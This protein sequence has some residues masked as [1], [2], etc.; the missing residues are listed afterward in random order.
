MTTECYFNKCGHH[1]NNHGEPR[2]GPFCDE[3]TCLANPVQLAE[4]SLQRRIDL[5][6]T[7][8]GQTRSKA[9]EMC[10]DEGCDHHGKPHVCFDTARTCDDYS[11][12][13]D[14]FAARMKD[15]LTLAQQRGKR[16]WRDPSWTDE[17][18]SKDLREHCD[19]GDPVDVANYCMF[20]SDRG[21]SITTTNKEPVK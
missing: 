20:L 18:I 1:S 5:E 12:A 4:W 14:R 16:G 17:Q 7:T 9:P 10:Q 11:D 6:H 13:V 19:K 8:T 3:P 21:E 15:K 2:G